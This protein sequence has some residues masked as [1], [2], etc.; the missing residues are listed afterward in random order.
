MQH[1]AGM[2]AGKC[3]V[4][5][6]MHG[7]DGEP[8]VMPELMHIAAPA[9]AGSVDRRAAARPGLNQFKQGPSVATGDERPRHRARR[10]R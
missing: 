8:V 9:R 6:L 3:T 2:R 5:R 7:F 10:E 1:V 4:V